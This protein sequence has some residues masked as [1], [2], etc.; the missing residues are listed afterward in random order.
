MPRTRR[1]AEERQ[2]DAKRTS[3]AKE[4]KEKRNDHRRRA[5]EIPRSEIELFQAAHNENLLSDMPTVRYIQCDDDQSVI[6]NRCRR[7]I[8]PPSRSGFLKVVKSSTGEG[9]HEV[10]KCTHRGATLADGSDPNKVHC[11]RKVREMIEEEVE[12]P[13]ITPKCS[14]GATRRE[15]DGRCIRETKRRVNTGKGGKRKT[16]TKT[17]VEEPILVPMC[18]KGAKLRKGSDGEHICVRR[19]F[20]RVEKVVPSTKKTCKEGKQ[21]VF[22]QLRT[23]CQRPIQPKARRFTAKDDDGINQ[24]CQCATRKYH[25]YDVDEN[26][27]V[28]N[29]R[30][31]SHH[32]IQQ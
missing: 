11:K 18:S 5:G 16:I 26:I 13:V 2:N 9:T 30:T 31:A 17:W 12:K 4:K 7:R 22:G 3:D 27:C 10:H 20:T 15:S 6:N 23:R 14:K 29:S 24:L 28:R 32:K 21:N 25:N 1:S 8:N 19:S